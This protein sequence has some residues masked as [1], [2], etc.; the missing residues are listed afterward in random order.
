VTAPTDENTDQ[1]A[2]FTG[3]LT[4]PSADNPVDAVEGDLPQLTIIDA[5]GREGPVPEI[6]KEARL[7]TA[8]EINGG[9]GLDIPREAVEADIEPLEVLD[10][11]DST[12]ERLA[13]EAQKHSGIATGAQ[14]DL[15]LN[16]RTGELVTTVRK[17]PESVTVTTEE[18]LIA[19]TTN[20][21]NSRIP[22]NGRGK[23]P[24]GARKYERTYKE[25][26][27]LAKPTSYLLEGIERLSR[28]G[29]TEA[30]MACHLKLTP[31]QFEKY[32]ELYPIVADAINRGHAGLEFDLVSVLKQR[33][34]SG[35]L[36]AI[37]FLLRSRCGWT[38][39]NVKKLQDAEKDSEIVIE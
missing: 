10:A 2:N 20:Y 23:C 25:T 27:V 22:E 3:E 29:M 16:S 9:S 24:A 8:E 36:V 37:I 7:L 19:T 34:M 32:K 26:K 39:D 33:A 38:E 13:E 12:E 31:K 28:Q 15:F 11:D 4:I 17:T 35:N 18:P 14:G 5:F 30:R 1:L 21:D 6:P